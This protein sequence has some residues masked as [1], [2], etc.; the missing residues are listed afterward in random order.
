M[1][2]DENRISLS[3]ISPDERFHISTRT[4]SDDMCDSV[5][6]IGLINPPILLPSDTGFVIVCGF[7]RIG[8]CR[9][10]GMTDIPARIVN[11]TDIEALKL[12]ISDNALQ[13]ALNRIEISRSLHKLSDFI[14]NDNQLGR[15]A[16]SLGLPST[17]SLIRKL[18]N[19]CQMPQVLQ[20]GILSEAVALP[21]AIELQKLDPH[22]ALAIAELFRQLVPSLNKQR[23]LLS[24][25]QEISIREDIPI[26]SL[27]N[28]LNDMLADS[29]SDR[30]QKLKKIR[31][32]LKQ[33]RFPALSRAEAQF[34]KW[35]KGLELGNGIE[36]IPPKYFEGNTYTFSM[37]F[38]T[39][40]EL[41]QRKERLNKI[42]ESP[43]LKHYF[44]ENSGTKSN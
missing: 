20:E 17:L 2:F 10:L 15:I 42:I 39:L 27:L 14:N 12:A 36:L 40:D 8:A 9:K 13:R 44:S 6:Q 26:R 43:L 24:L 7:R 16:I 28:D 21:T 11:I 5:R 22:D 29:E 34:D 25:L 38:T 19:L 23:E 37:Q 32:Y 3:Q 18:K 33:R 35:I 31:L 41:Y 4:D 30:N 1:Y